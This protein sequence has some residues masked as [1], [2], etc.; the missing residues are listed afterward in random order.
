MNLKQPFLVLILLLSFS[1]NGLGKSKIKQ[2]TDATEFVQIILYGQ[3]LGMGWEC[4]RAITTTPLDGNYMVGNNV[5]MQY[6]DGST[7]LNPLIATR[8]K[9]G[10]EQPIVSCVNAFSEAYRKEI[11]ANQKFIG[12]TGG[13]GGQTVERLSKECTNE[14]FYTSTF[15]KILDNTLAA[16]EG[17]TVSCPAILYMQGEYNSSKNGAK[18]KGLTPGT[19]GTQDK[20]EYKAYLLKLKNNMQADIMSKYNQSEKPL[21]FV[22]QTSGKYVEIKEMPIVMAQIELAEEHDDVIL[23]NPHYAMPDYNRG[24]LSTNGYR[25]FGEYMAKALTDVLINEKPYETLSPKKFSVKGDKIKIKYNT[26]VPPLLLDTLLTPSQT[27]YG[28]C[29]YKDD[30]LQTISQVEVTN[31]TTVEISCT[32]PLKGKIEVVYAGSKTNGSGNL[33]DSDPTA[34]MYT[35]YD[36][37]ADKKKENYTPVVLNSTIYGKSYGLQNWS[38]QFYRIIQEASDSKK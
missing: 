37:S 21:F 5:I 4:K 8:W 28:F 23:L 19:N 16:T 10:A 15:E 24:H 18:G 6:N 12:M 36:D 29:V 9:S 33:R 20:D 7:V 30:E 31:S 13:Q 27:N 14:G 26:P 32:E 1:A 3:S 38:D 2:T 25:W 35:Y 11:N 17:K 34:S 22:Y